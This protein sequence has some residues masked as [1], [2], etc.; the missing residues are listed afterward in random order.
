MDKQKK[1]NPCKG[2]EQEPGKTDILRKKMRKRTHK[3]QVLLQHASDNLA[4]L[5]RLRLVDLVIYAY[6][7]TDAAV[8]GFGEGPEVELGER[9]RES[10]HFLPRTKGE[11]RGTKRSSGRRGSE[12]GR[13]EGK[14]EVKHT[15]KNVL[16]S[17]FDE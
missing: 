8:H 5:S 15:S 10:G 7:G 13:R 3:P 14:R 9:E 17:I 2:S 6:D 12:S 16:S 1:I 11:E 4:I